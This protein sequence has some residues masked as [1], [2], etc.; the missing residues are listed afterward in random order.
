MKDW[1]P[2]VGDLVTPDINKIPVGSVLMDHLGEAFVILRITNSSVDLKN[3][4]NMK[5][6]GTGDLLFRR[7][8]PAK[9]QIVINILNDL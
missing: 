8:M 9:N 2:K 3:D 4:R 5:L 7:F 1:I 6:Q